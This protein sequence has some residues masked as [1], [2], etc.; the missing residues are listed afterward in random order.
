ML[1]CSG[2]LLITQTES[3]QWTLGSFLL[4]FSDSLDVLYN[5]FEE[6]KGWKANHF[7]KFNESKSEIQ[8]LGHS[9][10][11]FVCNLG[12]LSANEILGL[13]S[14]RYSTLRNK[15]AQW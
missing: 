2:W 8:I 10:S 15:L 3:S 6:I 14:I 7:L 1:L 4:R 9:R 5:C 11:P 13:H 12:S